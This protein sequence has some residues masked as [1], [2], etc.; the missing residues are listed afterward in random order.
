VCVCVVCVG[1]LLV[2]V[3]MCVGVCVGVLL[4]CVYMCVC[5]GV[6]CVYVCGCA[7]GVCAVCVCVLTTNQ[8]STLLKLSA[9]IPYIFLKC[10]AMDNVKHNFG[11]TNQP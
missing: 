9:Q 8:L 1:V 7:A 3:F 11:T 6:L 5:M 10:S 4:V 2:C